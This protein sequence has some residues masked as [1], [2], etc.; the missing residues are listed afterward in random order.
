MRDKVNLLSQNLL[1]KKLLLV[2]AESCTGG[3]IAA[4]ITDLS[5]S[6]NV[7]ERGF[8]TYSNESKK[9]L[10]SVPSSVID[11]YGAVSEQCARY[12]VLGALSS[13][14]A[15][16]AVSVTGIAGPSGGTEEKPVGLVYIGVGV[17]GR[18]TEV[19][20]FNFSGNRNEVRNLTC[21]NAFDILIKA[22]VAI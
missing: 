7:F 19:S 6:S 4:A 9:E 3:M 18:D 22:I 14:K 12:M 20:A 17:R 8:V 16:I 21:I 13:S 1:E 2:T 10:L 15:D 5:G 11:E